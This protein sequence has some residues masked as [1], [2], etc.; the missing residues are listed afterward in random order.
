MSKNALIR[1]LLVEDDEDDFVIILEY[2]CRIEGFDIEVDWVCTY[3]EA[4]AEIGQS[5]HD[6]YIF[7]YRLGPDNGMDLIR[8]TRARGSTTPIMMLTRHC[9]RFQ[10]TRARE[11]GATAFLLKSDASPESLRSILTKLVPVQTTAS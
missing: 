11:T 2:L 3:P 6:L 7:D 1:V 5:R 4:V 9:D 10:E 8:E